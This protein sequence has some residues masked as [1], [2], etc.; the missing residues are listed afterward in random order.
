MS[1]L[2]TVSPFPAKN[3]KKQNEQ[4]RNVNWHTAA[5][6]AIRIDLRDYSH[7]LEFM[8]EY[9]LGNKGYYRI[10][11]LVIKKLT[12]QPI[13]KNFTGIFR[14]FNLFEVKGLG[15][16]L[17]TD[18]YFKT[19]GYACLLIEQTGGTG[20]YVDTDISLSFVCMHYPQK[21][22]KYL[23][24]KR[25]LSIEKHAPGVYYNYIHRS[26]KSIIFQ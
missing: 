2:N 19:L 23:T 6:C 1:N 22:I 24:K 21:L 8:K 5:D 10:D 3:G 17:N 16:S 18:G 13:P 9:R 7:M 4:K 20:E 15:S 26:D 14:K 25:S 11:I 12:D